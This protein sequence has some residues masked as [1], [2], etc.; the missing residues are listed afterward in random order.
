MQFQ[1][2]LFT[3]CCS[4]LLVAD[5]RYN[6]T[7]NPSF[8]LK[9]KSSSLRAHA[10]LKLG[11][12]QRSNSTSTCARGLLWRWGVSKVI[13]IYLL[14]CL[15]LVALAQDYPSLSTSSY[16]CEDVSSYYASVKG[17]EGKALKKKLHSVISK[18]QSLSYKE[19]WDALKFLDATNVDRPQAS[20][21][22]VEIYSLRAVS[23]NLAG[24][25]EGWNR[26]HLWP[27]SYGLIS[28]PSLTDLHNIR[29]A[30][31]NVR[32]PCSKFISGKQILWRMQ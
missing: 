9:N 29:P 10:A 32:V 7:V 12:I 3:G 30:D 11:H 19:V 27:R 31:V 4:N 1:G 18:H 5:R 16:G 13:S 26:E 2:L 28:G 17:L 20:S 6:L 21:G 25:P 24:K 8:T 14:C 15:N 23:K 22:I